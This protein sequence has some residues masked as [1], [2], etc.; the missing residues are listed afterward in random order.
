MGSFRIAL[1][2]ILAMAVTNITVM[3]LRLSVEIPSARSSTH[4]QNDPAVVH[5]SKIAYVTFSHLGDIERWNRTIL[6]ALEYYVPQDDFLFVVL[7]NTSRDL[8]YEMSFHHNRIRP[9]FVHCPEGKSG[10][11]PCCKQEKGLSKFHTMHFHEHYDWVLFEDD[12]MYVRNDA[13]QTFVSDLPSSS[14]DQPLILRGDSLNNGHG[15]RLGQPGYWKDAPYRCSK[16]QDFLY[17]WGQPVVYNRA[18]FDRVVSAFRLGGLVKQCLEYDVTHD[19]G[20][21]IL[22][23]MLSLSSLRIPMSS[24]TRG[25]HNDTIGVHGVGRKGPAS[26]MAKIHERLQAMIYPYN[27]SSTPPRIWHNTTAFQ[28]TETY[29][30]YGDPSTWAN[31]EWHTMPRSDCAGPFAFNRSG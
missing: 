13:L 21:A 30:K 5:T 29:H 3:Q 7:T 1:G 23:W 2:M 27:N 26:D 31:E 14:D 10:E 24:V 4:H 28:T 25:Y 8:Y 11:S 9:L 17:P 18:A 22:H 15:H 19:A 12:D 6:P 16:Q 20:N